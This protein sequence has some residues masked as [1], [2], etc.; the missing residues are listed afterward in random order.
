MEFSCRHFSIEKALT[1]TPRMGL[2]QLFC[3]EDPTHKSYCTTRL[4]ILPPAASF[5]CVLPAIPGFCCHRSSSIYG[6]GCLNYS[7]WCDV[8]FRFPRRYSTTLC[9]S[10][11]VCTLRKIT[12][13][14]T[15]HQSSDPK[16][17]LSWL[18]EQ[19]LPDGLAHFNERTDA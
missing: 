14:T 6:S 4:R 5:G 2:K 18:W 12:G 11:W 17:S 9:L 16:L 7:F 15:G 8:N 19:T 1:W 13:L 10:R 3:G